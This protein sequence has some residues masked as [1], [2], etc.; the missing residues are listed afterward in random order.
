MGVATAFLCTWKFLCKSD[1]IDVAVGHFFLLVTVLALVSQY[2]QP[3]R[4]VL[5]Q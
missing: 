4:P 2:R 1:G 5:N 3:D